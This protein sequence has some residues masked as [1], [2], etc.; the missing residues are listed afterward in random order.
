MTRVLNKH[1]VFVGRAGGIGA[2]RDLI[3]RA[4]QAINARMFCDFI[5]AIASGSGVLADGYSFRL[6]GCVL[7]RF[8][9]GFSAAKGGN[10]QQGDE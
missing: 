7:R 5:V 8:D 6:G 1:G 2:A 3:R 9:G 4:V 10:H